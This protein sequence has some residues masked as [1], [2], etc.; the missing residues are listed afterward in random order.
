MK[1]DLVHDIQTAYRKTLASM[2]RPGLI[3]NLRDQ[4]DKVA[5]EIGCFNS[6]L[7]LALMLFDTEVT[8]KICSEHEAEMAK[9][10]NQLTYA[11]ATELESADYILILH[12]SKPGDLEE[13]FQIARSGDLLDPHKGATLIIETDVVSNERNL[14]LKGPGIEKENYMD[15]TLNG[16]WVDWREEK[17]SEYPLGIDLIFTDREDNILCL[18]RTTQI[19]KQVV[20]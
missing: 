13:A 5:M 18:P 20:G 14:T 2:S 8:F 1:L 16:Q 11:K 9:L 7:V 17:N 15:V 4:A 3:K 19:I 12:D 6:T 10:I